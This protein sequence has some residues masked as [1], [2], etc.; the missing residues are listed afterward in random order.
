MTDIISK[1]VRIWVLS[2]LASTAL[3]SFAQ[4]FELDLPICPRHPDF[5]AGYNPS[6]Y[7]AATPP[8]S[9][10]PEGDSREHAMPGRV[11]FLFNQDRYGR[12]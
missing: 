8:S 1:S 2:V 9:L 5:Q 12:Y 7:W 4:S 6:W 11:G 10:L 3:P